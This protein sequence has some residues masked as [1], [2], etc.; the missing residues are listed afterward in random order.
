MQTPLTPRAVSEK[1][2]ATYLGMSTHYLRLGRQTGRVGNRTASPSY[3]KAGRR[4]L[5]LLSDLDTWLEAHR[6]AA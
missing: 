4:V 1:E 2:A 5:Y 6:R 3:I